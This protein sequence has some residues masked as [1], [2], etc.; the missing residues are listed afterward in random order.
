MLQGSV[1]RGQAVLL[2]NGH[3]L[4]TH[5]GFPTNTNPWPLRWTREQY[6]ALGEL[7]L[8]N[9]RHVELINGEIFE[10]S[11]KGWLHVVECRKPRRL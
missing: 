2:I 4:E 6:Y 7:G 9:G 10:K 1:F 3:V 11:T 5:D 8:F